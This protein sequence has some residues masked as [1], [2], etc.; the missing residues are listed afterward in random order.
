MTVLRRL[1][2]IVLF[3]ALFN[4]P[5]VA[6]AQK[7]TIKLAV[8]APLSGEQAAL[9]EHVKL[10]AQLAVEE[11]SKAF[12]ALGYDLVFV[13]YDDQAKPEV[14]VANARNIVADPNVLALVGHFNS[15]VALP[16]SEVYKDAMLAMISP[17]NTATEITDRGYPNVNRVCGRDDV[18]GPVG[19]R[20]A[21]QDLKLKSVYVIHDK[22]LYGQGVADN[23]RQEAIKLGLKVLGYDGTEERAN[24]APMII[25]MRARNPDLVYFG[26]IYYQGGLLLKQMREKG[27]K[28]AFMGPDGLDSSEMV[29][30]TGA[31]VI[32]SYYTTVAG[33]PDAYPETAAFAKKF[34]QRFGKEVES[35]GMYGYDAAQVG[36]KAIEQA[37][38][39]NGGKK[40]S[41]AEVSAAVRNL[42]NF[43]G[44]TGSITFDNKGDPVKAKY[45][46]LQFDKRSYPGKV[47]KVIE[48]Q[49]P[50]ALA[51]K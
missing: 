9:G 11:A 6:W 25:P 42:K 18:Q 44:V 43:K 14:G 12:K 21:A 7:G 8:Q 39:A 30:I 29:K 27:V 19:A 45:F 5:V 4:V 17:A 37:I 34:K 26:G 41:R 49:A 38:Q 36:L 1:T 35:F 28:A 51:R 16:A 2:A 46:V 22:T 50:Q 32:G 15:G 48:Q 3:T 33:P 20:F 31:Q 40:P 10:G 23:F 47:V 24:F 13:P